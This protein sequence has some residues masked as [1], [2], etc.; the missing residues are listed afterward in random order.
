MHSG[1][2]HLQ[3][4][5]PVFGGTF[6]AIVQYPT[7]VPATGVTIGPFHWEATL[8]APL[9]PGRFPVCLVSHGADRLVRRR[10]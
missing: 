9:A 8:D 10:R 3:V 7:P 4:P 2:Q 1:F 5:D 6:P